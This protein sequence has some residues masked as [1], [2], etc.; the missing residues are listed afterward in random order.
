MICILT[1][2]NNEVLGTEGL[3]TAHVYNSC[4]MGNDNI[5]FLGKDDV[6][7][8]TFWSPTG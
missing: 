6:S 3:S 8:R 4:S 7:I 5:G 1:R 2:L